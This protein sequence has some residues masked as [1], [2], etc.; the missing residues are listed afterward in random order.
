LIAT[1]EAKPPIELTGQAIQISFSEEEA[2][3]KLSIRRGS[4]WLSN[5]NVSICANLKHILPRRTI[6]RGMQID[7]SGPPAKHDFGISVH[8]EFSSKTHSPMTSTCNQELPRVSM[9][10]GN[11]MR[12]GEQQAKQDTSIRLRREP[13]STVTIANF[14]FTKHFFPGIL[15]EHEINSD[16][17]SLPR[18]GISLIY[19]S[20][21]SESRISVSI[22]RLLRQSVRAI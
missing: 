21:D 4:D 6:N 11:M 19:A 13:F 5:A 14:A 22:V 17:K 3:H 12:S 1:R 2:K 10:C 8:L 15:S 20:C 16:L 18:K 7:V 9:D